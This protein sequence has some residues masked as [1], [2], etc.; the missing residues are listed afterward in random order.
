MTGVSTLGQSL[1]MVERIKEQQTALA[2]LSLQVTSGKKTQLF[3]GLNND[4]MTSKRARADLSSIKAYIDNIKN[5]ERRIELMMNSI[6]EFKSQ[7]R[8]FLDALYSLSQEGVHQEGEVI[9]YDDPLT[10]GTIEN[11]AYGMTSDEPDADLKTLQQLTANVYRI[12][13]DI[14]NAKDADRYI[15]AGADALIQ[16]FNNTGTMDSAISTLIT[17]WKA[18]TLTN[19]QIMDDLTDNT[20]SGGNLDALTDTIAGYSSVLSAGNGG[21]VFIRIAQNAE[22]NYTTLANDTAF[23]DILVGLSYIKNAT[24]VPIA[25]AY[26]PPNTYPGVPDTQGAPGLT[27]DEQKENFYEIF[28]HVIAMVSNAVDK[29]DQLSYN[30]ANAESRIHDVRLAYEQDQNVLKT[31]IADVEDVDINEAAVRLTSLE[32]QINAS[33]AVTARVQQ[34]SLVN[35]LFLS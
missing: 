28:N 8:T 11:T 15:F 13:S 20:T 12:V 31:T 19:Q 9:R 32:T 27:M 33:Y 10:T 25:D 16:P 17:Q 35:F 26:E 7:A 1:D 30:L 22:V 29:L 21:P 5:G 3:T 24:L 23:R 6:A 4:V 18:G 14:V 2:A 34:L